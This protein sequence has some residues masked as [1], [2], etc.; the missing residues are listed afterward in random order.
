[1]LLLLLLFCC[2][3][4]LKNQNYSFPTCASWNFNA[5]KTASGRTRGNWTNE[6]CR[7]INDI[8]GIITCHCFHLANFTI[9]VVSQEA[10]SI[11]LG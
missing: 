3:C 2:F 7:F 1:M 6:R 9:L 10:I 8:D 11:N 5:I 4:C